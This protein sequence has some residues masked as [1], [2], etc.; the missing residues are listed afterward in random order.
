MAELNQTNYIMMVCLSSSL[1]GGASIKVRHRLILMSTVMSLTQIQ[2]S[3]LSLKCGSEQTSW[4]P[5]VDLLSSL[6]GNAAGCR[7]AIRRVFPFSLFLCQ[8]F[9]CSRMKGSW[10]RQRI[11]W[12][13]ASKWWQRVIFIRRWL[14]ERR[15]EECRLK[16]D[17]FIKCQMVK[18]V[19]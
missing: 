5:A 15:T 1:M 14:L 19:H 17:V 3:F 8:A 2:F 18:N 12:F 10:A 6:R 7:M 11:D 9:V 16:L 4:F 13:I